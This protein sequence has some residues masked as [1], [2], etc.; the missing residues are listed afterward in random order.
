M[1]FA[2]GSRKIF[3]VG[4]NLNSFSLRE[5]RGATL[6]TALGAILFGAVTV[7]GLTY[8]AV[9]CGFDFGIGRADLG[10][11]LT[12]GITFGALCD[13]GPLLLCASIT[14]WPFSIYTSTHAFAAHCAAWA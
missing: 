13:V 11:V 7:L 9:T 4:I 14:M 10:M 5:I 12:L 1:A 6:R 2:D 8:V 3:P